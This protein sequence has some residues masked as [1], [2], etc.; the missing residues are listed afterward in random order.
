MLDYARYAYR[1]GLKKAAIILADE[2]LR[3]GR[4]DEAA[5]LLQSVDFNEFS[6]ADWRDYIAV[7]H[8][9][10]EPARSKIFTKIESI[11]QNDPKAAYE[12]AKFYEKQQ[13][14]DK[15]TRYYEVAYKDGGNIEAGVRLGRLY[16]ELG[17][18]KEGLYILRRIAKKDDGKAA[19]IVA[20][21]LYEKLQKKLRQMNPP[22]ISFTFKEPREFF[23]KKMRIKK[24]EELYMEKNVV[25][26]YRLAYERGNVDGM[27]DLIVLDIERDNLVRGKS[28]SGFDLMEAV[29]F[30]QSVENSWRAKLI[31]AKIYEKYTQLGKSA[32]QTDL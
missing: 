31:L 23:Y 25:P 3:A 28:Y 32:S 1:H 24:Y 27:L 26:W 9:L 4:A 12:L 17:R 19:R 11:A 14:F 8:K 16:L 18:Q 29:K 10:P 7:A 21:Y 13:L 20:R 22:P 15:A 2:A 30:L 5:R 6:F